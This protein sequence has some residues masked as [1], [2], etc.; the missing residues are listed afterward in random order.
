MGG[1]ISHD[2]SAKEAGR[3]KVKADSQS[4]GPPAFRPVETVQ[5]GRW[6]EMGGAPTGT[7][8]R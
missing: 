6:V 2:A 7:L 4:R 8:R 3:A 1:T 5:G